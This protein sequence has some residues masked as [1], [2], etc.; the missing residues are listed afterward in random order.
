VATVAMTRQE[1]GSW[2][3]AIFQFLG[4]TALAYGVT[5]IVYQVGRIWM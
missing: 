2:R 1:T 4:L 3:W 5:L